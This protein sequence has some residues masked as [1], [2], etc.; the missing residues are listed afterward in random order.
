MKQLHEQQV[1]AGI[2]Y[3]VARWRG[4]TTYPEQRYYLF[5]AAQLH[6]ALVALVG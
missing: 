4:A 6:K 5:R 1:R 3:W 2:D